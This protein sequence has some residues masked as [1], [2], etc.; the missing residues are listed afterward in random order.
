MVLVGK[1]AEP[2]LD[3]QASALE[4]EERALAARR[5]GADWETVAALAGY[6][7]RGSA[8]RAAHNALQRLKAETV[9]TADLYRTEALDRLNALL[10][11]C[12]EKAM[13]GSE[14][15]IDQARKIISDMADLTGAK[16]PVRVEI[17]EGDID[18][19]LAGLD[20]ELHRRSAAIPGEVVGGAI[21]A[22][23]A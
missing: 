2:S 3:V 22:G 1:R 23:P 11:A 4:K 7:S 16:A 21:E 15:H 5:T 14:R 9:A 17:G 18:R 8:H 13:A 20:A 6:G 10:N 19:L 12:W